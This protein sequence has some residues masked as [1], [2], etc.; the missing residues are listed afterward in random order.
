MPESVL[1]GGDCEEGMILIPVVETA[2]KYA[3]TGGMHQ[4]RKRR[5]LSACAFD[6][7]MGFNVADRQLLALTFQLIP[8]ITTVDSDVEIINF[9]F[10]LLQ[11]VC[12]LETLPSIT[13]LYPLAM[14]FCK[15]LLERVEGFLSKLCLHQVNKG[16]VREK[17]SISFLTIVQ[18]TVTNGKNTV[19]T[20]ILQLSLEL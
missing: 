4:M 8:I 11:A 15:A 18:Y 12:I 17:V 20:I 14:N 3:G 13:L 2:V 6:M 7:L 10:E 9:H 19:I 5:R 16:T 1:G